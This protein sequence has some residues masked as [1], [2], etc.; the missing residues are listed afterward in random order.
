MLSIFL[1]LLVVCKY[2]RFHTGVLKF[3]NLE[4]WK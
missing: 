4:T 3:Q 2:A 1:L